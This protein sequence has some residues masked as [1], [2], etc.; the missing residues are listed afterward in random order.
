[1]VPWGSGSYF[2]T[3]G[4]NNNNM[5]ELNS[6]TL[7]CFLHSNLLKQFCSV[8]CSVDA[9]AKLKVNCAKCNP[10]ELAHWPFLCQA[11]CA[12]KAALLAFQFRTSCWSMYRN[13][14]SH[15][16]IVMRS[17]SSWYCLSHNQITLSNWSSIDASCNAVT[18][19]CWH[20]SS[21]EMGKEMRFK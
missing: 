11:G 7:H 3:S 14:N 15:I 21:K 4:R 1:M 16:S 12:A 5:D 18:A 2:K 13:L 20:Y 9:K 8:R 17:Y 6:L 10:F 19:T